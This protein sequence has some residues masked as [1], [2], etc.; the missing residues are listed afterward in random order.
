MS[1]TRLE[2]RLDDRD[3]LGALARFEA[4]LTGAGQQRLQRDIG[5]YLLM[6]TRD[7]GRRQV[8]PEG[9]AWPALSPAYRRYKAKRRPGAPILIFDDEMMGARL[10]Y[11]IEGNALLLGTSARYGAI[12]QLGG[13]IHIPARARTLHFRRTRGRARFAKGKDKRVTHS[14]Q[15]IIPAH[16]VKIPARKWIGFSAA[17]RQELPQLVG[18]HVRREIGGSQ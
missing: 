12:H 13:V 6:S 7:R 11:Q 9:S 1:G 4:S 16:D 2:I 15:T 17:D 5:E 3:A 8:T 18:T 14:I 10:S